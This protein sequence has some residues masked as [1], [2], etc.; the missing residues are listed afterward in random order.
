MATSPSVEAFMFIFDANDMQQLLDTKPTKVV[1]VVSIEETTAI[2]GKKVGALKI[3][4]RGPQAQMLTGGGLE[5]TGC[6]RPPCDQ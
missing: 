3:I 2:D 5:I 1:C 4:A 6:P